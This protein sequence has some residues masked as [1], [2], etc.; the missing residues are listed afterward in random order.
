MLNAKG[1][2]G[3]ALA[4]LAALSCTGPAIDREG[5]VPLGC[6]AA[7][8]A[9][10]AAKW[11]VLSHGAPRPPLPPHTM[12]SGEIA[13]RLSI[14]LDG[15]VRGATFLEGDRSLY[16]VYGPVLRGMAFG[17]PPDALPG[18]W[19]MDVKVEA[20]FAGPSWRI[21]AVLVSYRTARQW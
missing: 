17:V 7:H 18:P 1:P 19:E 6:A 8:A 13:A 12:P 2:Y 20:A 4:L 14:G 21:N 5:M 11:R 15:K 9:G 3:A 16:H 10:G